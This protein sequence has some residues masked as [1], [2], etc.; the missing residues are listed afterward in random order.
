MESMIL[1][2]SFTLIVIYS[3][4]VSIYALSEIEEWV[5]SSSWSFTTTTEK[6]GDHYIRCQ[7][8][9]GQDS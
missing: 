6:N 4:S 5:A 1:T 9:S 7:G 2:S 3:H 8:G